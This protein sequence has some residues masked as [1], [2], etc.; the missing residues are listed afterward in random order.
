LEINEKVMVKPT[1]AIKSHI[2]EERVENMRKILLLG[3]EDQD[4]ELWE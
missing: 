4:H 2:K 3:V 1:E